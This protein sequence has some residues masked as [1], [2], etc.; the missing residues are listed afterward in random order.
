MDILIDFDPHLN[1]MQISNPSAGNRENRG[2]VTRL[3]NFYEE[4]F[5]INNS[6]R[7]IGR[8]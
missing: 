1:R 7:D 2:A 6:D 3:Y 5:N 4:G 8:M